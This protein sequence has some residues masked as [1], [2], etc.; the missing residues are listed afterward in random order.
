[1]IE[2][3]ENYIES[4]T[5]FRNAAS[6]IGADQFSF[7]LHIESMPDLTI[8]VAITGEIGQPTI[9][10]SSGLHGVEGHFGA[11]VQLAWLAARKQ[12]P[13]RGRFVLIHAL[14]PFGYATGRRVNEDNIDLNRNFLN[15]DQETL[16]GRAGVPRS[17]Y[18]RF[19]ALLNPAYPPRHVDGFYIKA[20]WYLV[21]EGK[22]RLQSAIV[23]GQYEFER[24]LFYG[25]IRR[26]GTTQILQDQIRSW[27]G[28]ANEVCHLDFHTGLGRGGGCQLLVDTLPGSIDH[29]WYEKTFGVSNVVSTHPVDSHAYQAQGAM[30]GWLTQQFD[31]RSYRFLTAE[32]GTYSALAVLSALREENQAFHYSEQD[33]AVRLRAR[34]RLE[35]SFCP[36]SLRWRNLVLKRA[37]KLIEQATRALY[38]Y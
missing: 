17:D 2:F 33:S 10:I 26:S 8:D 21:R 20:L 19:D 12:L 38:I 32:F 16:A 25:G 24:G 5:R 36:A 7:P 27:V 37:L 34:Q 4:R 13:V 28:D 3:P 22:K 31:D 14:N 15:V 29:L 30:G 6:E 11:A 23:T 18:A 35:R 1:M 9:V